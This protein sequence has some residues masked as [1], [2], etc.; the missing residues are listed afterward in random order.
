M[1]LPVLV[2][3][4]TARTIEFGASAVRAEGSPIGCA[5][6]ASKIPL[7]M[8]TCGTLCPSPLAWPT[9]NSG[10]TVFVGITFKDILWGYLFVI[11]KI[12]FFLIL[13]GLNL[14]KAMAA[15]IKTFLTW[16]LFKVLLT[17]FRDEIKRLLEIVKDPKELLERLKDPAKR[18]KLIDELE[19]IAKDWLD[20]MKKALLTAAV[21]EPLVLPRGDSAHGLESVAA[22]SLQPD[23]AHRL[24]RSEFG[25]SLEPPDDRPGWWHDGDKGWVPG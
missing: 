12:L 10:N 11:G 15:P 22:R 23:A 19:D 16:L 21:G 2:W 3:P 8:L 9:T 14:L 17:V 13:S 25:D 4:F 6:V 7:F 24:G 20:R 18:D 5:D 1:L